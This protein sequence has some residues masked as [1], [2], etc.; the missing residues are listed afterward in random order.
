MLVCPARSN[1]T[2]TMQAIS[3]KTS[4][5]KTICR[6]IFVPCLVLLQSYNEEHCDSYSLPNIIRVV[7]STNMR[8]N[9]RVARMG[10]KNSCRLVAQKL[11][12][13]EQRRK[14][15]RRLEGNIKRDLKR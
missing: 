4:Y 1:A 15:R 11:Q 2:Q 3:L 12:G 14:V 6:V 5:V 8:W 9:C 10:R 13:K 7:K